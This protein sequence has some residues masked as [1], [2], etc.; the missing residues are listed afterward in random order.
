MTSKTDVPMTAKDV[1]GLLPPYPIVLVSTRTNIITINQVMYFT[2]S[3]L[4]VGIA[5]A[6]TRFTFGLLRDEGEFVINV[7]GA[8]LVDAVK[9][10][11]SVSGRRGDKFAAVGLTPHPSSQVAAVRVA[12]CGAHIEC[13]VERE[14]VFENRTWFV[15]AVVAASRREGHMGEAALLC[16]RTDYRLPGDVVAGR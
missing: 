7:P 12:E 13:R 2:F 14:I 5:V 15:G 8:D 10:C 1:L 4:R 16:G 9:R 11:G 3:P 6:H